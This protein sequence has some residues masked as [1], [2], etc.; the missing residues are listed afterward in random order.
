[1]F[2]EGILK[3]G[4]VQPVAEGQG[5]PV[6]ETPPPDSLEYGYKAVA[7]YEQQKEQIVKVWELVPWSEQD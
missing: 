4:W 3:N 6:V 1:M 5:L 2:K 7:H